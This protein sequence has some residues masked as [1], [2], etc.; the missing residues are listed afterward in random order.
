MDNA[1]K[2]AVDFLL[3]SYFGWDS[4]DENTEALKEK[5]AYR[6]YLDLARTVKY[7]YSSDEVSK[8]SNLNDENRQQRVKAFKEKKSEVIKQVCTELIDS[9]DNDPKPSNHFN[10]WR[11]ERCDRIIDE[12]KSY[13]ADNT[14]L[15]KEFTYGQAQKWVNMTLKYLWMLGLLPEKIKEEEL[16]VPID[17]FILEQLKN[18]HVVGVTGSGESYYYKKQAWSALEYENYTD[19]Q[20]KIKKNKPTPIQWEKEVWPKIARNRKNRR[21]ISL[22]DTLLF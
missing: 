4:S 6:A 22:R 2:G 8:P 3:F 12:M 16:H 15:T 17:S 21:V 13:F 19:L 9:I 20:D 11:K 7:H 1:F 10:D 14:A 18:D 5:V